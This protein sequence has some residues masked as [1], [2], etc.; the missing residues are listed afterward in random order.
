[1]ELITEGAPGQTFVKI[2]YLIKRVDNF[3]VILYNKGTVK[4]RSA[5]MTAYKVNDRF[6]FSLN[7]AIEYGKEV[8]RKRYYD[9]Y[10]CSEEWKITQGKK[11]GYCVT[12]IDDW[13]KIGNI[14]LTRESIRT[15]E[16]L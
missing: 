16:I 10:Q 3:C 6:Y 13:F 5:K 15:I 11:G 8:I 4:E 14:N 9:E 2:I 7:D 12:V 1:V